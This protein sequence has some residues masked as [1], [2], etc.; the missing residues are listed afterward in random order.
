MPECLFGT[1]Y[2]CRLAVRQSNSFDLKFHN[3]VVGGD[4]KTV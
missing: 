1:R 3:Q 2:H 4:R